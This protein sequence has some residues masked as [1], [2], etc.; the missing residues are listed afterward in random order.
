M[1]FCFKQH[2]IFGV[3]ILIILISF[4]NIIIP[5]FLSFLRDVLGDNECHFVANIKHIISEKIILIILISFLNILN[6][7]A[8]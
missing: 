7:K 5:N 6:C 1:Y 2:Q 8:H 4:P 3:I